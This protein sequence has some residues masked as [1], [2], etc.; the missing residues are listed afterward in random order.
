MFGLENTDV[1]DAMVMCEVL[2][3]GREITDGQRAVEAMKMRY[4]E[5]PYVAVEYGKRVIKYRKEP[6]NA[7]QQNQGGMQWEALM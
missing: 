2:S 3:K 5:V 7:P 1:I 6:I 4:R